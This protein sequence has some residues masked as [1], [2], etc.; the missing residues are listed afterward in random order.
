MDNYQ[1]GY[2]YRDTTFLSTYCEDMEYKG[3]KKWLGIAIGAVASIA[4]PFLAPVVA[5]A[6]GAGSFFASTLGTSLIGAGIGAIGGA[7]GNAISGGNVLTGA[8]YGGIGGGLAT[9][10]G[11]LLGGA[12]G[13]FGGGAGTAAATPAGLTTT[14]I[15]V[16]QLAGTT[17][18]GAGGLSSALGAGTSSLTNSF[19]QAAPGMAAQL[20]TNLTQPDQQQY[21]DQLAKELQNSQAMSMA[22]YNTK[23]NLFNELRNEYANIDPAYAAQLAQA[24]VM[25]RNAQ[26][27]D[28]DY[29]S[30]NLRGGASYEQDRERRQRM[31]QI[32]GSREASAAYAGAFGDAQGRRTQGMAGLSVPSYNNSQQVAGLQNLYKL[33]TA[34]NDKFGEDIGAMVRPFTYGFASQQPQKSSNPYA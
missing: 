8:L 29:R 31:A 28:E 19:L 33:Q 3:L 10:A 24:T 25:Q 11:Q 21:L 7:A 1:I 9:G 17:A 14:G 12:G 27:A 22:E 18:A 2:S 26:R 5:G 30:Q 6:F 4:A 32:A 34:E 16:G 20:F 13:L 23:L 15:E